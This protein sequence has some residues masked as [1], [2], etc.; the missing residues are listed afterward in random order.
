LV[1][2]SPISSVDDL[3]TLL[4]EQTDSIEDEE[5]QHDIPTNHTRGRYARS[6]VEA[7]LAQQAVCKVRTEV[8]EVTR[9]MLDRRNANFLLW[10]PCV[11]VQR[12]S[13]CC[14]T[15]ALQCVPTVTATR[16][17]QV[18]KIQYI[19]RNPHY[20][21]A[22]IPVEDHVSCRCQD[23]SSSSSSSSS[24]PVPRAPAQANPKPPPPPPQQP[25]AAPQPVPPA[26]PKTYA[27]KADLHRHDDLKHNQQHY[28]VE[29]RE[30]VARQWQPGRYT[31]MARWTQPRVHHGPTHAL[32]GGHPQTGVH[33]PTHPVTGAH[34][35]AGSR[36]SDA[37]AEQG[38]GGGVR[39]APPREGG[40]GSGS[41]GGKEDVGVHRDHSVGEVPHP[42]HAQRQQQQH[43]QV[44]HHQVQH[45]QQQHQY[46]QHKQHQQQPYQPYN[47][48]LAAENPE[49]RSQYRFNAPQSDSA[50]PP[51]EPTAPPRL[52]P[53]NNST[54]PAL[55]SQKYPAQTRADS[56]KHTEFKHGEQTETHTANRKA[57]NER[58][59]PG[60]ASSGA[61]ELANHKTDKDSDSIDRERSFTEEERR[62][63][64]LE[65]VK[66]DP[67]RP[68]R[69]HPHPA[70]HHH[71]HP[72]PRPK[73]TKTAP[74]VAPGLPL[75]SRAP[76]RPALPRRRRK[77]RS[78]I[79]KAAIRAM[80]M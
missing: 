7:Q 77:Y 34:G 18:I 74:T 53:Q 27:S 60:P 62:Q 52:E 69:L 73:P 44:Q 1:R 10:P 45:H 75:L 17:L 3:K 63:K 19:N 33:T 49:L 50:S 38:A 71:H 35:Q 9:S 37:R 12:C 78:R 14:N 51:G 64:L 66:G 55:A 67:D 11:E 65:I 6:L 24:A 26:P 72:H 68:P 8:M 57:A 36:A 42:D 4:Q 20:E 21:K 58:E 54:S 56:T 40:P 30:S 22:I 43:H 41:D 2:T 39:Q 61:S 70:D 80:I 46:H 59:N 28:H 16:Y 48:G 79:S 25:P 76:F 32:A 13:G 31:Q 15:R 29:E 5:R 47:H 23:P